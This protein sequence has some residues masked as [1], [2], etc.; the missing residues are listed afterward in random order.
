[1]FSPP[2]S[3]QLD[4]NARVVLSVE[5]SFADSVDGAEVISLL[6]S[7]SSVEDKCEGANLTVDSIYSERVPIPGLFRWFVEHDQKQ[8]TILGAM[9]I[10]PSEVFLNVV[11]G[12]AAPIS[13]NRQSYDESLFKRIKRLISKWQE[14]IL[15]TIKLVVVFR[16]LENYVLTRQRSRLNSYDCQQV[17]ITTN[18]IF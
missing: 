6:Q 1:M 15:P 12:E 3:Y 13:I 8:R 9:V 4:Y 17:E 14:H 16:G 18:L 5:S 7:A 10:C 2:Q 11:L